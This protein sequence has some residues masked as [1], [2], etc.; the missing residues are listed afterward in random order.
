MM[1]HDG[2]KKWVSIMEI[3]AYTKFNEE[4]IM[5]L[6]ASVG[7]RAYTENIEALK[8]GFKNSLLTLAAYENENLLGLVRVVGDGYTIVYIQ[9]LLV[10]PDKQNQHVGTALLTAV[11]E[12]YANVRQLV[13]ICDND[14]K[15]IS[16]YSTQGFCVLSDAGCLGFMRYCR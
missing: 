14:E 8:A 4:E 10:F 16:F 2:K 13:L 7:W 15:L 11:K 9:D 1:Y 6:Y 3:K 12:K 5:Q